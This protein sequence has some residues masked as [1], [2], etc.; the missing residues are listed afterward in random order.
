MLTWA[1]FALG[2]ADSVGR[3]GERGRPADLWTAGIL[4]QGGA[5]SPT[6]SLCEAVE[7]R[8]ANQETAG[9]IQ[10]RGFSGHLCGQCVFP[11]EDGITAINLPDECLDSVPYGSAHHSHILAP[12]SDR[13][14][15]TPSTRHFSSCGVICIRAQ[16]IGSRQLA[17]TQVAECFAQVMFTILR[18]SRNRSIHTRIPKGL[19][20]DAT[21]FV[22]IPKV[23][24]EY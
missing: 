15:R 14:D 10:S 11:S 2:L 1:R 23:R 18:S 3:R 4:P 5:T 17:V 13:I 12:Q 21:A 8:Y 16:T 7:G 9:G 19:P 6:D 20:A 22:G 24:F